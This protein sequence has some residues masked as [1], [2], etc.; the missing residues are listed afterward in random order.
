MRKILSVLLIMTLLFSSAF[1]ESATATLQELYAQAEL[2][3]VQGDYAGAATKFETLGAY[4]DASQMAMYC[5]AIAAAE[6]FG[7]YS[8]AV[9]A[10]KNLGDFK[11]SKQ[12][13]AYYLARGYEA[14]GS[15]KA[16]AEN[17]QSASDTELAES[18]QL[19][20][21]ASEIYAGLA[22]FKD[23]IAR[24][25]ACESAKESIFAEQEARRSSERENRYQEAITLQEQGEYASAKALFSALSP[26]KDCI[27]RIALCEQSIIESDYMQ[28]EALLSDGKWEEA[29]E[30]FKKAGTYKDAQQRIEYAQ[31]CIWASY[32]EQGKALY[33]SGE[34]FEALVAFY[35]AQNYSDSVAQRRQLLSQRS[36]R[37][38]AGNDFTIGLKDDGTVLATGYNFN[39]Q[40]DV[41]S[42]ENIVAVAAGHRHTVGLRADGTVAVAGAPIG[43]GYSFRSAVN[44]IVPIGDSDV[45]KWKDIV[46]IAAGNDFTLGLKS[47]GTVVAAG[48]NKYVQFDVSSWHD[49]VSIAAGGRHA[50]GLKSDG[51]VVVIGEDYAINNIKNNQ[52]DWRD[53]M[54]VAAGES[55]IV[56][57][58][59]DGTVVAAGGLQPY[60]Y[61]ECNVQSWENIV[62]I[63]CFGSTTVGLHADGTGILAGRDWDGLSKVNNW[64]KIIS[65]AAGSSHVIGVCE[66]GTV[67]AVG[68][69]G[70]KQCNVSNW[71][72]WD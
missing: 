64:N 43:Y 12:L 32:Y 9:D 45:Y 24:C 29:I 31:Q 21:A 68:D 42:W 48:N 61:G 54:E 25:A 28:G 19:L 1:A 11:D 51:T 56:G 6:S 58:R 66:D 67:V 38:A 4:S 69:N 30:A 3:M 23:C 53:I 59:A 72:L 22:L 70:E 7:M 33:A 46:A 37:I 44:A 71:V 41:A 20:N 5:K 49:I 63:S 17:I 50:V 36:G 47:D 14:S 16:D 65:I 62:A 18:Y 13:S 35:R 60:V 15:K 52:S 26:Y 27:E 10:F 39:K 40:C 34:E 55:H 2:L 57:L 8:V